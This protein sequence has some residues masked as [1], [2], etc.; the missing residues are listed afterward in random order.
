MRQLLTFRAKLKPALL[1]VDER[2]ILL[3]DHVVMPAV[4]LRTF[5]KEPLTSLY[6]VV[7]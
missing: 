6:V 3:T 4:S 2:E 1:A 5:N 7:V